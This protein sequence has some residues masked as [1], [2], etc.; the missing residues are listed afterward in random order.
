MSAKPF[1]VTR[2]QARELKRLA[3]KTKREGGIPHEVV[4]QEWRAEMAAELKKLARIYER[5]GR[6]AKELLD[7]LLIAELEGVDPVLLTKIRRDL[8]QRVSKR[9][10]A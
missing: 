10:A 6:G 1:T 5:T 7:G 8:A 2:A 4:L 9:Q 3:E